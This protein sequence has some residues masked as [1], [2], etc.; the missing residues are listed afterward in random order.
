MVGDGQGLLIAGYEHRPA[1]GIPYNHPYYSRLLEASGFRKRLDF[2]SWY[3]D[4][5]LEFPKEFLDVAREIRQRR[6]FHSVVFRTKSELQALIPKVTSVYNAS[7]KEVLG[8]VPITGAEA[9]VVGQRILS[10]ADPELI[11]LLMRGD[12]LVGFVLAYPDF[13]AAIQKSNGRIWPLGWYHLVREAK[14]TKWVN[15]NG[16]AIIEPYRGLGGNALMYA[17]L[18]RILVDHPQYDYGDLV[19]VQ[20]TNTRVIRELKAVGVKPYKRHRLYQRSLRSSTNR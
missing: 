7:F 2:I 12:D 19:Q 18:H 11:S 20:E 16:V 17:E 4:R 13:S 3:I 14:R 10:I 8:Y 9:E 6:G 1:M 15:F 5:K